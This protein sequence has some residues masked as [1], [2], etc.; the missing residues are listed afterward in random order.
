MYEH[1]TFFSR[2][3]HFVITSD[4]VVPG[5]IGTVLE[6]MMVWQLL[7]G[8]RIHHTPL[9]L[10]GAMWSELIAWAR[11]SLLRPESALASPADLDIPHCVNTAAEAIARLRERHAQWVAAK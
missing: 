1:G 9:I 11:R 4:V 3:H 5:G 8:Q 10:V 2:L 6:L 7:Q